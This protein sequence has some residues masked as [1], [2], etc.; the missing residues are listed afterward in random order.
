MADKPTP[1]T[2][3]ELVSI[4]RK[5]ENAAS[6]F[7][8]SALS[9]TRE[10]ALNYYDREPYGDEQEGAS[11]V[12]TSEFADVI[13][14]M[15][16]S[17]MR[18][19]AGSDKTVEFTPGAPGQEKAA[20]E[21]TERCEY[22]LMQ[23]ND[24]FRLLYWLF[25]DALMYRLSG[26]T[27]D[28][29]DDEDRREVPVEGMTQDAI[30]LLAEEAEKQGA[31]LEMVLTEDR[32]PATTQGAAPGAVFDIPPE[33]PSAPTFSGTITIT[34]KK[35]RVIADNIAPEDI[36]FTPTARD[37]DKASFLGFRK[38]VTA[39][40]LVEMGLSPEEAEEIRSDRDISVEETQR[41]DSAVVNEAERNQT[42]DS[43][44]PLWLVVAYVRAD[45]N[46]DGISEMLRVVYAHAGGTVGRVIE[47]VEWDGPASIA[48]A[49]P[50]LMPHTIVGRSVFDQVKDLQLI[51][52]V[53]TRGMLD[54]L[55]MVNRPRPVISDQ[56]L[57]D[58]LIDWV[59]G[60]PVRLKAGARPMDEHVR[61]LQ[62]PS[63][64]QN[65]L[66][67]LEYNQTVKENRTG[68]VRNNQGL[69]A[70]SLNKT[71]TGMNM[72]MG[73]AQQR[74]ELIARVFAETVVKRI[75]RLIYRA[76]KKAAKGPVKYFNGRT[77]VECDPTKWPD[78]MEMSVNVGS[79]SREQALQG[80]TLVATAQE[81]A[82]TLQGGDEG[83]YVTPDNV[84]NLLQ[85]LTETIGYKTPGLFFQPP[86]KATEMK[87]GQQPKQ[88]PKMVEVQAK[89]AADQ[90]AFQAEQALNQQKLEADI[91][92][93]QR[94]AAIDMQL[95]REKANAEL[96]AMRE[97]AALEL[98]LERDK[99][100]ANA[101][102]AQE[103]ADREFEL[104]KYKIANMPKPGNSELQ[105]QEV[106]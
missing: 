3:D 59:P 40:D 100:A 57:I 71:A 1:L 104:E 45:A 86:E 18:V 15:M 51:G 67:A 43:E 93:K 92:A 76:E 72:L 21:A 17:F 38:K 102:L 50:I 14:S 13:E 88:D 65:V 5:E 61:W 36:L 26:V 95:A 28:L 52:S 74:V 2:E 82:I 46:G 30:D 87:K 31:E 29:E 73:A 19:F 22:V 69:D 64:T 24:G 96:Q 62:V 70:D 78:D 77:F 89:I 63:V 106:S 80:L 11:S 32:D 34:Q 98:Q 81:K 84:A 23:E 91:M 79:G 6:N 42:G 75:Y 49:S 55:Y 105:R 83:P 47:Q 48:L 56:V 33:V 99:A 4:L 16:P 12:V 20:Q 53:L 10:D 90:A 85:K 27:V 60:S 54:N 39:S 58:S 94:Q 97:R 103:E 41:N 25:K 101:A 44:R 37:Q 66:A 35:K 7:Q 9:S 68:V 8:W